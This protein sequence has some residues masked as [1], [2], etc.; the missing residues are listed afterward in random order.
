MTIPQQVEL[1]FASQPKPKQT[2]LRQLHAMMLTE[3]PGCRLWFTDGKNEDGT[4][5]DDTKQFQALV[6][7]LSDKTQGENAT[8]VRLF[9]IGY[10]SGADA[11]ALRQMAEASNGRYYGATSD[12]TTIN[13]IFTQVI[14]NF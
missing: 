9:T 7:F 3:F 12:P 13:K 5:S 4:T 10:G 14:S 2:E 11:N 8:P 1:Y 6:R